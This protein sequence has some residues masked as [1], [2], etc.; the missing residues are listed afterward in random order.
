[1][2]GFLEQDAFGTHGGPGGVALQEQHPCHPD[3]GVGM[4]GIQRQHTLEG[5]ARLVELELVEAGMSV[6]QQQ[7]DVV[8]RLLQGV[9][10]GLEG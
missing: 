10:D 6:Q 8:G 7:R 1:M 5:A 3:L 2:V 4:A 9:A